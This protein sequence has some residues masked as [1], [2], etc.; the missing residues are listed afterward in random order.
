M[1]SKKYNLGWIDLSLGNNYTVANK[2][3]LKKGCNL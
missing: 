1:N 3:A 2:I